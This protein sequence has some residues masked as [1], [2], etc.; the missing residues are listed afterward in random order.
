MQTLPLLNLFL[1]LLNIFVAF[2][3]ID[4]RQILFKRIV[5]IGLTIAVVL[6]FFE[7]SGIALIVQFTATVAYIVALFFK[8]KWMQNHGIENP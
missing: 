2:F 8:R 3:S 4:C 1:M 6:S 5:I 7:L